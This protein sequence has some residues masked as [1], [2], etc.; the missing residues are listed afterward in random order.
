MQGG[1]YKD[2]PGDR[3]EIIYFAIF[4]TLDRPG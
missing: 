4:E 1:A 3:P 2:W